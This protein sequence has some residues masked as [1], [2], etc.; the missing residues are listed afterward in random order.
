MTHSSMTAQA[1]TGPAAKAVAISVAPVIQRACSCGATA[2]AS[3]KCAACAADERLGTQPKLAVSRPGDRYEQ[4]ADRIADQ[5]MASRSTPMT[6]PLPVTPLVQRQAEGQE[7][8]EELLQTKEATIGRATPG[9]GAAQAL[10]AVSA[11][12]APLPLSLR[13]WFEPRLGRDLSRVRLHTSSS[14]GRASRSINARAYTYRNHIAFAPGH[15]APD[16]SPGRRLLAHELAHT[17]Q[18]APDAPLVQREAAG[19]GPGD[20]GPGTAGPT[21]PARKCGP[22]VES[23]ISN[24]WGRVQS[25]FRSWTLDQKRNACLYLI[26]PF[27]PSDPAGPAGAVRPNRDAFDT[28]GLYQDGAEWQRNPPFHP[29]CGEPTSTNPG[30]DPFDSA[31]ENDRTC[32]NSVI[33][34]NGCWLMGTVNYGTF[35]IMMKLCNENMGNTPGAWFG[36]R[37]E[38]FVRRGATQAAESGE[39]ESNIQGIARA[40]QPYM[41]W[42]TLAAQIVGSPALFSETAMSTLVTIYKRIDGEEPGPPLAWAQ[43]TYSGGASAVPSGGNRSDCPTTCTLTYNCNPF[44]FVWEP[45]RT[46]AATTWAPG[47]SATSTPPTYTP[48]RSERG[49]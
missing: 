13:S 29:P 40:V 5:V 6:G 17:L 35:G 4:E 10:A 47:C 28:L 49:S 2:G 16:T 18:Q 23:A 11:G 38:D 1:Q 20:A 37:L 22:H 19:A 15:Y 12:G 27:V 46:R 3:G 44:D 31:H 8:E 7:E 45:V 33:A 24:V 30:A 36:V 43:A 39:T 41:R 32:S 42:A 48:P 9:S 21:P 34:R 26:T 14:A 25:T